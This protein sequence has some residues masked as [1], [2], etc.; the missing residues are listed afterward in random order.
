MSGSFGVL[1]FIFSLLASI[2]L[3]ELGHMLP[4]KKFGVRV[5]QYMIGFG[6]TLWSRVRGETEYGL[7][8][9][10][11]GGYV[12]LIGMFGPGAKP[13]ET[14]S[15]SDLPESHA[16]SNSGISQPV[17]DQDLA[18]NFEDEPKTSFFNSLV[19]GAR[20][21]SL[22]EIRDGEE[23][24]ALYNLS[25]P[26]KFIVMFGG[27]FM[28]FVIACVLFTIAGVFVGTSV[29][30]TSVAAVVACV[31]TSD[32][33]T[34]IESTDGT[35]ADGVAS[36]A[37]VAGIKLGDKLISVNGVQLKAWGDLANSVSD[38]ADKPAVLKF[39]RDGKIKS[40]TVTLP[41]REVPIYDAQGAD[42]GKTHLVG[43]VGVRPQFA[44]QKDSLGSMPGFIWQQVKDTGSAILS[45]PKAAVTLSQNLF[46]SKPREANGPVSV[47]GISQISGQIASDQGVSTTDKTW[48]FLMLIASL[49]MFLF[50]FNLVPVLPLDGGHLAAAIYEGARRQVARLRRK[51]LP[52]PVD[53]VKM[54]PIAY[55]MGVLLIGLSLIS[56]LVDLIK[57]IS[58]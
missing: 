27:P 41:A 18:E 57:P 25:A 26:K 35:C 46:S 15:E 32:N 30:T 42:T 3:H 50:M 33:P 11:L 36:A 58:F 47:V 34:G 20:Q 22:Q 38:L 14:L 19:E 21:S 51:P 43:F 8:A 24:R 56:V 2:G 39:D 6:P 9:I 29:P 13:R 16:D 12:R 54:M 4:A 7:K 40:V 23:S 49:N 52:G 37:K 1:I 44:S 53:T 10:P 55:V 45:F 28:N 17:S 5:S 31:P 48:S